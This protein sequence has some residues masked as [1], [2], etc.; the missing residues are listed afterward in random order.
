MEDAGAAYQ[1]GDYSTAFRLLR[2]LANGG[3]PL[4]QVRLGV[5]Y[6]DGKG[7]AQ[8]YAEAMKWYRKAA[9]QGNAEGQFNLAVMYASVM[10]DEPE[11][12]KWFRKAAEQGHA[13]SQLFLGFDFEES[14][15]VAQDYVEAY[16]W[17]SLAAG[18]AS[19]TTLR[20]VAVSGR[21]RV[22]NQMTP[23]EIAEA[24]RMAREWKP[25]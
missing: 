2:S 7:V 13:L 18:G 24:Q 19:E 12:A 22:A 16:I 9:D 11:A 1:R 8:D 23:E 15:G 21:D 5:L 14:H 6:A 25:K 20:N 17:F 4:A 10:M 3:D